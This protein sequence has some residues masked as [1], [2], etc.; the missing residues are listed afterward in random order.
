MSSAPR[1]ARCVQLRLLRGLLRTPESVL[2]EIAATVG[3]VC[4]LGAGPL[5][6]I[7][8]G[9][10]G[11]IR[12]LLM[13][14]P[15]RFRWDHPLSP[16]PFAVGKTTMLASA[17]DEHRTRRGAVQGAFSRRRLDRWIP[18][19][20]T[21]TDAA[22]DRLV[23]AAVD[24]SVDLYPWGRRL[25]LETVV[26]TLFGERLVDRVGE[27]DAAFGRIQDHLGSPLWRQLP[28]PLSSRA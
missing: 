24:G 14:P 15:E 8:L 21:E 2:D 17:G 6:V 20:V 26:R 23:A 1:P 4:E 28:H 22:L 7:V 12:E 11:A 13:Q 19:I 10:P 27:I 25:T 16:F 18:M 9:A 3:P 5:R